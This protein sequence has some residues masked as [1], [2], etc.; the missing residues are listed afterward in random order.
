[1]TSSNKINEIIESLGSIDISK[2]ANLRDKIISIKDLSKLLI[3]TILDESGVK[4]DVLINIDESENKIIN[5]VIDKLSLALEAFYEFL[6]YDNDGK[7]EIVEKTSDN[8]II[9]GDD[10]KAL[11]KDINDIK[12]TFDDKNN[13][14]II[15]VITATFAGM[16]VYFN[17]EKFTSTKD[18]FIQFKNAC[19]E[20]FNAIKQIKNINI[21]N[22]ILFKSSNTSDIMALIINLC[23]ISIPLI[24]LITSKIKNTDSKESIILS[25][26]EIKSSIS[27]MYGSDIDMI[28]L[29]VNNLSLTFGKIIDSAIKGSNSGSF[30]SKLCCCFST[31]SQSNN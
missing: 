15:L 23:I 31:N 24:S 6:D 10:I 30:F 1:M 11:L 20:T 26:D 14:N 16:S 3:T 8:K 7:V 2:L 25:N 13:K 19:D 27:N 12:K 5:N 9:Q 4:N 17:S 28:Q 22:K 29:T 18:E 21:K